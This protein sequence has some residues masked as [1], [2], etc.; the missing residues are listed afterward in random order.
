MLEPELLAVAAAIGAF[1]VGFASFALH[2][3]RATSY[4]RSIPPALK[5]FVSGLLSGLGLL[6]MLP[7]ALEHRPAGQPTMY[8]LCTFCAAPVVMFFVNHVILDHQHLDS[9]ACGPHLIAVDGKGSVAFTTG[10][11]Q[12]SKKPTHCVKLGPKGARSDSVKPE[13][14]EPRSLCQ[15]ESASCGL[16]CLDCTPI[17]EATVPEGCRDAIV[18]GTSV[19]LRALPYM[20][21]SSIDGAVLATA[22]SPKMLASLA[23]PIALCA[24]QDV[25]TILVA[26]AASRASRRVKLITAGC[27]GL[28]FPLGTSLA[29]ASGVL[30]TSSSSTAPLAGPELLLPHL[31]AFAGGLFLYMALFELAPPQAHTHNRRTHLYYLLAFVAGLGLTALSELVEDAGA[32]VGAG[33]FLTALAAAVPSAPST[34]LAAPAIAAAPPIT[35]LS[36]LAA[37]PGVAAAA[38]AFGAEIVMDALLTNATAATSADA[39]TPMTADEPAAV[40]SRPSFEAKGLRARQAPMA[41]HEPQEAL[42]VSHG[43]WGPHGVWADIVERPPARWGIRAPGALQPVTDQ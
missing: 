39:R 30:G 15:L 24:V 4:L 2:N 14:K 11:L 12:F 38:A 17:V 43:L 18:R 19:L 13:A 20:L 37:A 5:C 32:Q 6:V 10:T 8:L 21:H 7:S 33:H 3:E 23:L 34:T 25:G 35:P 9:K 41:L 40:L 16:G 28:G 42:P 29:C 27:F 26:L 31:R 36:A 22:T 1:S